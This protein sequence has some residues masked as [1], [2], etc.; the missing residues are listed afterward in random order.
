MTATP[1]ETTPPVPSS[2]A[3]DGDTLTLTFN[4]P[5][6]AGEQP[7]KSTF[8]V[9]VAGAGRGVDTVA[10]SG[11]LVTLTLVTAVFADDAVTMDYTATTDKASAK[12]QDL[13]GNLAASFGGRQAINN[14]QAADLLMVS[15]SALPSS[16]DGG[17]AFTFELRFSE[18]TRDGFSYK[19]M[20]DHV[21]TVTGGMVTKARRMTPPSNVS[22]EIHVTPD[23]GG[24]LTIVLPVTTDCTAEGAICTQDRRPLSSLLEITVPGP[25]DAQQT[26]PNS[27][28]AGAPTI[29]G[30]A[31]VGE[32]LTASTTSISDADG[33]DGVTFAY[34]WL[35]GDAE[36]NGATA[37]AYTLA[38]A[39]A[40]K[41]VKVRVNFTDDA[42]NYEALTSQATAAVAEAEPTGPPPAPQ[43]LTAVV[44]GDGHI[45]LS[46][47]AP[48]DDSITGY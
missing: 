35:A 31:Q 16:H 12:L 18:E 28:A 42:G 24:A 32:T 15:V 19:T 46:W 2:A 38:D 39:D 1:R 25:G 7:D 33:L 36:I 6:D 30:A 23:G 27:R 41:T 37:S 43:N 40:G 44:N 10:V 14:T 9:T 29:T 13:A 3:V 48:G 4:E 47:E 26:P 34:Q 45:V 17:S 20:Q 11:S 5:L 8:A 22:W 21:F